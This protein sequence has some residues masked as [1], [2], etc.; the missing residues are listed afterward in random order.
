[1][2]WSEGKSRLG[3]TRFSMKSRLLVLIV[4][5]Q[6]GRIELLRVEDDEVL[7]VGRRGYIEYYG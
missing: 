1:M 3:I 6:G 7:E 2:E 5:L 4:P